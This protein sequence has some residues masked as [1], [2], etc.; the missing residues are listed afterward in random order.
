MGLGKLFSGTPATA[1]Y[2]K[3]PTRR[4]TY[5]AADRLAS[6]RSRSKMRATGTNL[7]RA[8]SVDDENRKSKH[9]R[10]DRLPAG[11]LTRRPTRAA[12]LGWRARQPVLM[13]SKNGALQATGLPEHLPE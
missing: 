9:W 7:T 5:R 6:P 8:Q 11:S 10:A 13:P 12:V 4:A 2:G 1:V 3:G